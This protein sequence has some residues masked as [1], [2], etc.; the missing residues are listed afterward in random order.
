MLTLIIRKE[1]LNN[2]LSLRFIVTLLLFFILIMGSISMMSADYRKQLSDYSEG[3]IGMEQRLKQAKDLTEIQTMGLSAEKRPTAL[4]VFAIGLEKEMTRSATV[5]LWQD[6][7]VGGSKYANPLFLLYQTPDATYIVNIVISLLAILFVFDTISG[8]KEEGTLKLMLSN[9]VP[10][11]AILLGKWIGGF[12]SL[13]IP[14]LLAFFGG[15]VVT[16]LLAP[17]SLKGDQGLNLLGFLITSLLYISAFFA[18]GMFISTLTH[19]SGTSL[20]VA[21]FAWVILVL[22]I[23]NVTPI[24]ARQI[25]PTPSTGKMAGER[26]AIQREEFEAA[27]EEIQEKQLWDDRDKVQ[28]RFEEAR[29]GIHKR[30]ER[31]LDFN[32]KKL[33]EQADLAVILSRI[34]PSAA[35]VY[36]ATHITGTGI[37]DFRAL[38]QDIKR[39]MGEYEEAMRKIREARQEQTKDLED[40]AQRQQIMNAKVEIEQLPKFR[41]HERGFNACLNSALID[42][43]LL[44]IFNVLFFLGAFLKFMRYDV[45]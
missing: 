18:L 11:D 9:S 42:L 29:K 23:P 40:E 35:Y 33:N 1:I 16:Y 14:F 25:Q 21:L 31:V 24:I 34:S 39:F 28:E 19:R 37:A 22:T 2:I 8:E 13:I 7:Q 45:T 15:W 30:W 20:M 43:V 27:R 41:F 32:R 26:Q 5:N 4:G 36:G 6:A 3:R 10:R 17:I 44:V 12:L 38:R